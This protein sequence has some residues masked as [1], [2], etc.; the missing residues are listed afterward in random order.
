MLGDYGSI[1]STP[2]GNTVPARPL[3]GKDDRPAS[4]G[5]ANE[6]GKDTIKQETVSGILFYCELT[7][8]LYGTTRLK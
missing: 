6:F 7:S 5:E 3:F 4:D 8:L 1:T 2:A